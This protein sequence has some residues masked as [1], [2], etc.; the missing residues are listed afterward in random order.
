MKPLSARRESVTSALSSPHLAFGFLLRVHA[1]AVFAWSGAAAARS[2]YVSP[3]GDDRAP[4]TRQAPFRTLAHAAA[5]VRPGDVC[6]VRAG[7]YRETV[8]LR[9]SGTKDSPIRFEAV[10]GEVV[11]LSGAEPLSGRWERYRGRIFRTKVQ[12][13][14]D[15]LFVDGRMMIEARWPNATLDT[16]WDRTTWAKAGSGSRYGKIV[17]PALAATETDWTGAVAMLNVAHQFY[18]WTRP[19]VASKSGQDYFL[20]PKNLGKSIEYRYG[21]KTRVWADDRFYLFGKLEALDAPG[22]WYLDRKNRAL[23]L[24]TEDGEDPAGKRVEVKQR[25]YAFVAEG[26]NYIQLAGFHFFG[27]AFLFKPSSNHCLVENCHLLYP[28]YARELSELNPGRSRAKTVRAAMFGDFNVIRN[29]SLAYTPT[30]GFLLSGRQVRIENCLVHNVCWSGSLQ[31]APILTVG[32]RRPGSGPE[33]G[34]V[35]RG[36]TIFNCGNAALC[37][38]AQPTIIEYNHVYEGGLLCKDVA[39]VYTGGPTCAGSVVRYNWVHGC[40]TES[41]GG[42]GIRG[43]DQTRKLTVHHNVVW[44]CGAAG[45]IVKGDFNRVDNNTVLY[46]GTRGRPGAFLN[47]PTRPEPRKPWRKQF[48]LLEVQNSHSEIFNNAARTCYANRSRQTPFPAGANFADNYAGPDPGL[49]DPAHLDFRPRADS[50]LVDAG[51]VIPGITDR[52]RGKAPDIGA[53]EFG[54]AHWKPGCRNGVLVCPADGARSTVRVALL[55]PPL[56]PVTLRAA[57]SGAELHFDAVNWARPQ[58][59]PGPVRRPLRLSVE[60]W[61][62]VTC[63]PTAAPQRLLFP[64]PEIGPVRPIDHRFNTLLYPSK[65]HVPQRSVRPVARAFRAPTP[66]TVDGRIDKDEWPGDIPAR[67]LQLVGLAGE[68]AT[69]GTVRLLFDEHRIYIA[70]AL[71]IPPGPVPGSGAEWGRDDGVEVDLQPVVGNRLGQT[72]VLHGYPSGA[73]A[74]ETPDPLRKPAPEFARAV[75]YAARVASDGWTAEFSIPFAALGAGTGELRRIRFNVGARVNR[76]AGGPWFAWVRTGG[77]NYRLDEA[78]DL[79]WRPACSA[80]APNLVEN[81]TFETVDLAP[82]HKSNNTGKDLEVMRIDRTRD[83]PGGGWCV[84]M[85][86]RDRDRMKSGVF[87]WIYPLYSRNLPPGTYVLTYDLRIAD[88]NP[89]SKSG[90]FCSYIRTRTDPAAPGKGAN[91]GRM[92]GAFDGRDLP[93]T[94]RDQVIEIPKGA[95]PSFISL[96]LHKAVGVVWLDNVALFRAGPTPETRQ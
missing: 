28:C 49:M 3:T 82:W 14:F 24:W 76:A 32:R 52:F 87:K 89:M 72:V 83:A 68:K 33:P 86:C 78:G 56:R 9:R 1:C 45:I 85:A 64:E 44:D 35:I 20:Y 4:G 88:L 62:D 66:V 22:E 17:C 25:D 5:V 71:T 93:W 84:R 92:D 37:F 36:N 30:A 69:A 2:W 38:R 96:Q 94:R 48:P 26:C 16:L 59:L 63:N 55:M 10:P 90:M 50:P 11:V 53:Y 51:R 42:L 80:T 73:V 21:A 47:M 23:Y 27:A 29:C 81:G 77:A 70:F 40:R 60:G 58:P 18:T 67:R 54:G 19:V 75:R 6:R 31:Y 41:G 15:Q 79:V 12:R 39:L 34:A 91:Q 7:T 61:G 13:E 8:T 57:P 74:A 43:D 65:T 95:R 46:I